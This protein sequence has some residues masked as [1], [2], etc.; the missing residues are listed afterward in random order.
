MMQ[1]ATTK[2]PRRVVFTV[3]LVVCGCLNATL[4]LQLLLSGA[5]LNSDFLAFWSFPR[6][7]AAHDVRLIYD[8]ASLQSFQKQL[9]PGFG[10][11]Y[12]EGYS[13]IVW[14]PL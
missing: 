11:F 8:A 9:Y 7:A 14:R 2:H 3:L 10:S 13:L 12:H 5:R 6:F 4:L 1:S